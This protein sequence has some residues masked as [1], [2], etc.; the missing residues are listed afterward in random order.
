LP[1]L[2]KN[3]DQDLLA[4]M[5]VIPIMK[6]RLRAHKKLETCFTDYLHSIGHW[7]N[8]GAAS[9]AAN[10]RKWILILII[11]VNTVL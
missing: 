5:A 6:F 8:A 9:Q 10:I 7:D 4:K 1:F 2:K 11:M 3:Q